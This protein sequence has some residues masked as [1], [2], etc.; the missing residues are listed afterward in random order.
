M[1]VPFR[2]FAFAAALGAGAAVLPS[3]NDPIKGLLPDLLKTWLRVRGV[4]SLEIP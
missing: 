1:T 2:V 3:L 4:V